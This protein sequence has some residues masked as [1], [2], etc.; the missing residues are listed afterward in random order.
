M[1]KHRKRNL[2]DKARAADEKDFFAFKY[3]GW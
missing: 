2:T 1:Q 3:F